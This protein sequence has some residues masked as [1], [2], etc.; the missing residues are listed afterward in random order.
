MYQ[1]QLHQAED[2]LQKAAHMIG[3]ESGHYL[4]VVGLLDVET[5]ALFC[6]WNDLEAALVRVNKGLDC[7]LWWGKADDF[8]LAYVALARIQLAKGNVAEATEAVKKAVQ[9]VQTCGIFSE[10]CRA[11]E[12]AQVK[13]WL[14][15]RDW[16]EVNRWIVDL[17]K[18]F[19][20]GEPFQH[21]NELIHITQARILIAQKKPGEAIRLLSCL[22]EIAE[23]NGRVGRLIQIL[24]LKALALQAAGETKPAVR[25]LTKSL[26]LAQPENYLRVFLD[27]G[28]PLIRLLKEL[29]K[30]ETDFKLND[31]ID[32]L[33]EVGTQN[34]N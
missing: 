25:L 34:Q 10:A 24:L 6:E 15:Q 7:L 18:R 13:L 33:L 31:Y 28:E 1:G 27:E 8:C 30:S 4:G 20:T 5:A 23:S 26:A 17:E 21:E 3:Q 32:R 2:L 29:H 12:A 22:E 14:A 11:V 9:L 16:P 19:D